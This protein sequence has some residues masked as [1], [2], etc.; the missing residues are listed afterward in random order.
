MPK[1][2][3][4]EKHGTVEATFCWIKWQTSSS[5]LRFSLRKAYEK[6]HY[7]KSHNEFAQKTLMTGQLQQTWGFGQA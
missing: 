1:S 2:F 5:V 3:N 6:A 4:R 7:G